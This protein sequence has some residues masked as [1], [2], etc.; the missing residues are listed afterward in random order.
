[1]NDHVFTQLVGILAAGPFITPLETTTVRSVTI[2][3]KLFLM[4]GLSAVLLLVTGGIGVWS[5]EEMIRR[6]HSVEVT[7]DALRNHLEADLMLDLVHGDVLALLRSQED[8]HRLEQRAALD[9]HLDTI[10]NVAALNRDLALTGKVGDALEP[11]DPL[12]VR[13]THAA[14]AVADV[15]TSN[16]TLVKQRL[17][18]FEAAYA[19]VER[20]SGA[21]AEL[22]EDEN[23]AEVAAAESDQ[24]ATE[25][26]SITTIIL[27]IF[28]L[29]VT[30]HFLGTSIRRPLA[31][32]SARL[33]EVAAGDGDLTARV[34]Y[35]A[36]DEIG[37]L[38]RNF[39]T[40][41]EKVDHTV[42]EIRENAG[43]LAAA[44]E[45]LAVVS[46]QFTESSETGRSQSNRAFSAAEG[47]SAHVT[48]VA[49]NV[50]QLSAAIREI[51]SNAA[52]ASTVASQAA[53]LA[54]NA[55]ETVEQLGQG[56]AHIG[57]VLQSITAVAQKTNLLALNATIEAARAGEAGKGFAVVANEVKELA[58]QAA[59]ST[60]DI[61]RRIE[62]VQDHITK[63]VD[64]IERISQVVEQINERQSS[65]AS[66]V[67]EQ[68]AVANDMGRSVQSA[69]SG[70]SEISS[71]MESAARTSESANQGAAEAAQAAEEVARMAATLQ[72]LVSQFHCSER[73]QAP[74]WSEGQPDELASPWNANGGSTTV[75][76]RSSPAANRSP[77]PA[78]E[79]SREVEPMFKV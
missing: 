22:I 72:H 17:D 23:D 73:S 61:G 52:E 46:R 79:S 63:V 77:G 32:V 55:N 14:A 1:M 78:R 25:A 71:L 67:E 40:F 41:V 65:I 53:S 59:V 13:Y 34:D 69:A 64:A 42:S 38:A 11:L 26:A 33:R 9:R 24:D 76:S 47:V 66:A 20:R 3:Q 58:N 21:V 49:S 29:V 75:S 68:S 48:S 35:A 57:E 54:R 39:N 15:A 2:R 28:I 4:T 60:D 74:S 10:T 37:E 18:D 27:S 30:M 43:S 7:G 50:D 51:A 70:A 36:G 5:L 8:G 19:E 45:E 6:L 44:A 31:K 12:W 62:G 56:S 16:E